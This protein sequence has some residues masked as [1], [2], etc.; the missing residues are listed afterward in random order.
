MSKSSG[1]EREFTFAESI[2][3][4][5]RQLETWFRESIKQIDI[6]MALSRQMNADDSHLH[7]GKWLYPLAQKKRIVLIAAGKAAVP[8]CACAAD[9]LIPGYSPISI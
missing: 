1:E 2:Q 4:A 5:D 7:I 6:E 9:I 3:I 8:M